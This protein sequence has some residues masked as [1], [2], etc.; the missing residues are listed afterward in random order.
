MSRQYRSWIKRAK[1]QFLKRVL[2][3]ARRLERAKWSRSSPQLEEIRWVLTRRATAATSRTLLFIIR[4]SATTRLEKKIS[5]TR[6]IWTAFHRLTWGSMALWYPTSLQRRWSKKLT[7]SGLSTKLTNSKSSRFY[8]WMAAHATDRVK[9]W[10]TAI[11]RG[12][13]DLYNGF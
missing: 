3:R 6:M 7:F 1:A 8:L 2:P 9:L 11:Q 4:T 5:R 12:A 13:P 10:R